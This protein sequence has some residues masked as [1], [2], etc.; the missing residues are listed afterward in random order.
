MSKHKSGGSRN[1]RAEQ[2]AKAARN[3]RADQLNPNNDKF[4]RSRGLEGRP[5]KS[6]NENPSVTRKS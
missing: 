3:N 5:D 6:G 4:H 1:N 2:A